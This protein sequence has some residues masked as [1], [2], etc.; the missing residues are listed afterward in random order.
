MGPARFSRVTNLTV[1]RMY[2][3]F[4][5]S[6]GLKKTPHKTIEYYAEKPSVLS[7]KIFLTLPQQRAKNTID[8]V[9]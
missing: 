2:M 1:M 8:Q 4:R 6:K 3:L 7:K 5:N 9:E